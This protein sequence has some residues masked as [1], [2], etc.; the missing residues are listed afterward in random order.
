MSCETI[1][2]WCEM[3][4]KKGN[5]RSFDEWCDKCGLERCRKCV[6]WMKMHSLHKDAG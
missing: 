5:G 3:L 4:E 1:I 2:V 6:F